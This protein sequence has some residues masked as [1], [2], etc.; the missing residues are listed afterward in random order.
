[1]TSEKRAHVVEANT[2][3]NVMEYPHQLKEWKQEMVC[4]EGA[5]SNTVA[6]P[7]IFQAKTLR[8]PKRYHNSFSGH[9][10]L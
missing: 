5:V 1:M 8:V 10:R 3:T 4:W 6:V 7:V 2:P 9:F